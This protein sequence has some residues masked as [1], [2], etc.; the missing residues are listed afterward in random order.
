MTPKP[1]NIRR[2]YSLKDKLS[3]LLEWETGALSCKA[4]T[5][6]AIPAE[7]L[8]EEERGDLREGRSNQEHYI[9]A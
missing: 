5:R 6:K 1:E 2:L 7:G 4:V 8:E 3:I 9:K